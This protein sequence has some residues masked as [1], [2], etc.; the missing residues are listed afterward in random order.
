[1]P[2]ARYMVMGAP[3]Y[4]PFRLEASIWSRSSLSACESSGNALFMGKPGL[5]AAAKTAWIEVCHSCHLVEASYASGMH[6]V[7]DIQ[8]RATV[9]KPARIGQIE[10]RSGL[11]VAR[12]RR[13]QP[14]G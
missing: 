6:S 7:R 2:P 4:P 13:I 5:K 9:A 14:R 12:Q 11:D 8:E 1:M 3:S 10:G